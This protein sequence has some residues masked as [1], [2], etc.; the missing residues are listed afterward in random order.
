MCLR[1]SETC[2]VCRPVKAAARDVAHQVSQSAEL[3]RKHLRERAQRIKEDAPRYWALLRGRRP[4]NAT[5]QAMVDRYHE[6]RRL[7]REIAERKLPNP[8]D[9]FGPP[10]MLVRDGLFDLE[11]KERNHGQS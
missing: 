3:V 10:P 5:E 2:D 9:A 1:P 4:L 8:R 7:I 11:V 6:N